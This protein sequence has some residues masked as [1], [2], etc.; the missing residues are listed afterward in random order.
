MHWLATGQA[1]WLRQPC[2]GITCLSR[3]FFAIRIDISRKAGQRLRAALDDL[4]FSDRAST[5]C[6]TKPNVDE[7]FRVFSHGI[8]LA[9]CTTRYRT[10]MPPSQAAVRSRRARWFEQG[11]RPLLPHGG[12]TMLVLSRKVDEQIVIGDDIRVT[13][14]RMRALRVSGRSCRKWPES[15]TVARRDC[16][17]RT[18]S[19][20]PVS[21][22][23]HAE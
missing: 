7:L 3:V 1:I 18:V 21:T 11:M 14:V 2:E 23:M 8:V 15:R 5:G 12:S 20:S 4:D 16:N 17:E 19:R 10:H 13:A 6:R 9:F 22:S